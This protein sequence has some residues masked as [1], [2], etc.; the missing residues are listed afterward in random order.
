MSGEFGWFGFDREQSRW[1]DGG[2]RLPG[3]RGW[4]MTVVELSWVAYNGGGDD[5]MGI[6]GSTCTAGSPTRLLEC[7]RKRVEVVRLREE[8]WA[9][10]A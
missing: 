7:S 9:W 3:H 1:F 8:G 10:C 4:R 5:R 2:Y 6:D